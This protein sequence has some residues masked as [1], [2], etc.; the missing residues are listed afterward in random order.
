M[1]AVDDTHATGAVFES[2]ADAVR[3]LGA[4]LDYLNSGCR[5]PGRGGLRRAADSAW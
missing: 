2:V 4:A 3:A 5:G 1:C